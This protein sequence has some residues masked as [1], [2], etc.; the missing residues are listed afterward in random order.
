MRRL[1][2]VLALAVVISA[3]KKE[4]AVAPGGEGSGEASAARPAGQEG[5][6]ER[7]YV[8]RAEKLDAYVG[9]QR[10]MLKVYETVQKDMQGLEERIL[11][12]GSPE[13]AKA[14]LQL[15]ESK[16]KAE[17]EA[18]REAQL[19]ADDINGISEVVTAVISQ[20]QLARQ[21]GYDEE[22]R[23]LEALQAKL[24]PEQQKELAPQVA[25]MRQR[26]QDFEGL[27]E[28]RRMHGE[29]N[30]ELVLAREKELTQ[31]YQDMLKVFS[32][33]SARR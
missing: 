8:I 11:K 14:R 12:G 32:G 23:K 33:G 6:E 18:R 13:A 28:L 20:R 22:Y 24:G 25:E 17:E 31:G 4:G 7:P 5:Q 26:A 21:M 16:A 10:R 15:I 1:S 19:T 9:Y 29:G 2:W 3:C 27:A 30:V